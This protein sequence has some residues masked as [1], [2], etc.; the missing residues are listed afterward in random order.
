MH[1]HDTYIIWAADK[2]TCL[3]NMPSATFPYWSWRF[4]VSFPICVTFRL[5]QVQTTMKYSDAPVIHLGYTYYSRRLWK[6]EPCGWIYATWTTWRIALSL[7]HNKDNKPWTFSCGQSLLLLPSMVSKSSSSIKLV[8][9]HIE[10][11]LGGSPIDHEGL[12]GRLN[13]QKPPLTNL[14]I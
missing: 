13:S 5:K 7:V 12:V 4:L 8:Q 1:I 9:F 2:N 10:D 6:Y 11:G 3:R 14:F